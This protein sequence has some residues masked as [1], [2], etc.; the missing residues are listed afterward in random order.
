[1]AVLGERTGAILVENITEAKKFYK[2]TFGLTDVSYHGMDMLELNGKLFFYM[3]EVSVEEAEEYR[4]FMFSQG[5]RFIIYATI[6]FEAAEK[7]RNVFDKVSK[8]GNVKRPISVQP[9]SPGSADLID[10]YGVHWY[11][12]APMKSPPEGCIMCHP[13][14]QPPEVPCDPCLRWQNVNNKC[15]KVEK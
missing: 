7:V 3:W 9:W 5:D 11:I 4:K 15:P 6:E 8:E 1:M 13:P 14:G 10:K 2:D 12:S